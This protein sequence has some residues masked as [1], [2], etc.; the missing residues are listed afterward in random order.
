MPE[1]IIGLTVVAIG[2]SLPELVTSVVAAKKGETDIAVGNVIGSC[3]F[4]ILL[5][6]GVSS[7]FS[8]LT[9]SI[10]G[11]LFDA[12]VALAAVLLLWVLT[13]VGG[14]KIGKV[15]GAI[16]LVSFVGY[17]DYLFLA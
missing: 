13:L 14:K 5:V 16:M 17:Y 1:R 10:T 7:L 9:F 6:A 3:I 12:L 15:A 4:N 2:T 8:P 11:N